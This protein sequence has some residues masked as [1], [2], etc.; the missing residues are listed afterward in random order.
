MLRILRSNLKYIHES[1]AW[2]MSYIWMGMHKYYRSLLQKSPIKENMFCKRDLYCLTCGWVYANTYRWGT[3]ET[4]CPACEWVM[5]QTHTHTHTY[6][7]IHTH[8]HTQV[9]HIWDATSCVWMSHVS[10]VNEACVTCEW[11]MS[12]MSHTRTHR[13]GTFETLHPACAIACTGE[14]PYMVYTGLFCGDVGLFCGDIGLFLG[15]IG[16]FCGDVGLFCWDVGLF[17]A[18]VG[19]FCADVGPFC[20]NLELFCGNVF[21]CVRLRASAKRPL[22]CT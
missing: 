22:W 6:T 20:K 12:H 2:L 18:H 21:I 14:A 19:L 11:V 3:F 1:C 4:I 13:C 17:C 9:R 5:V 8:T 10:H 7:H 16:L 15:E